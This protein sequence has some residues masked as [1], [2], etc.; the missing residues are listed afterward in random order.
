M[1]KWFCRIKLP[2]VLFI[3]T[4]WNC[5]NSL[6]LCSTKLITCINKYSFI[7]HACPDF[8]L[9]WHLG[10]LESIGL[11]TRESLSCLAPPRNPNEWARSNKF[12]S[13]RIFCLCIM[14][15]NPELIQQIKWAVVSIQTISTR[16]ARRSLY[17]KYFY[18]TFC[19]HEIPE[20]LLSILP[21]LIIPS[22]IIESPA[23]SQCINSFQNR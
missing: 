9:T 8:S 15:W 16:F 19:S 22:G 3:L 7:L 21:C 4:S 23:V 11:W 20:Q 14:N 18:S 1:Q 2:R 6:A 17:I 5:T 12:G 10:K 13:P